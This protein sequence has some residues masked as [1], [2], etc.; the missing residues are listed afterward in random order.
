MF[1]CKQNNKFDKP[2]QYLIKILTL[3]DLDVACQSKEGVLD[4]DGGLRRGFHELDAVLYSK[5]LPSLFRHLQT[6]VEES[7]QR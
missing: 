1:T 3:K 6:L 5:L 4:I 7:K 2:N